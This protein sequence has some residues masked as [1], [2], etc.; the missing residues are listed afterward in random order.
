AG[1]PLARRMI[2]SWNLGLIESCMA[3][4]PSHIGIQTTLRSRMPMIGFVHDSG[5]R[6]IEAWKRPLLQGCQKVAQRQA[7]HG[8]AVTEILLGFGAPNGVALS[9][10]CRGND[11][12]ESGVLLVLVRPELAGADLCSEVIRLSFIRRPS[13]VAEE[14]GD[15]RKTSQVMTQLMACD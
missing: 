8:N 11:R 14:V 9:L 2:L 5:V 1:A 4:S 7:S 12:A 15:E 13:R 6:S 3:E 10:G